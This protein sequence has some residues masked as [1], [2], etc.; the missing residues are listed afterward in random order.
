MGLGLSWGT[1]PNFVMEMGLGLGF[2]SGLGGFD[3][4]LRFADGLGLK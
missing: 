2:A 1:G 3:L 4:G